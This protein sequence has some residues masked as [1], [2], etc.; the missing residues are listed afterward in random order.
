MIV[1]KYLSLLITIC[2]FGMLMLLT[3]SLIKIFTNIT[4]RYVIL[5]ILIIIFYRLS[6]LFYFYLRND[7][8]YKNN[9][10][11]SSDKKDEKYI[12]KGESD[13]KKIFLIFWIFLM[14]IL[15]SVAL[16]LGA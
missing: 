7:E 4:I 15:L 3:S 13:I 16:I 5:V 14:L 9:R 12:I 10:K 1:N 8:Y 11:Q 2:F 6:K